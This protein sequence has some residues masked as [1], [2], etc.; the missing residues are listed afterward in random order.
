MRWKNTAS[1]GIR[2][3]FIEEGLVSFVAIYHK[4]YRSSGNIKIINRFLPR[5]VGELL[6]YYLWLV[7]PF[8][9][10]VQGM[11][12][13]TFTSNPFL[14]G[15]GVKEEHRNWTGSRHRDEE[16]TEQDTPD[17]ASESSNSN[18]AVQTFR[19]VVNQR[20]AR[21]WTSERVRKIMK[22]AS[23]RLMGV[24]LNISAWR[25]IAIAISRRFCR[26]E[27]RFEMEKTKM[28]KGEEWKND[29]RWRKPRWIR[30]KNGTKIMQME[31]IHGI[32]KQDM[33][34]MWQV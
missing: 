14:W 28:D 23:G 5:E 6:V 17:D 20:N 8:F 3:I 1:G 26:Q 30:V 31:M 13:R 33:E 16:S 19:T 4:G 11:I 9:E 18:P 15:D 10:G 29:L 32:C 24:E 34:V 21:A 12:T 27:E 2:N 7:V 22:E 25:Q